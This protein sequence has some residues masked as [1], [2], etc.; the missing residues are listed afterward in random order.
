MLVKLKLYQILNRIKLVHKKSTYSDDY[1][2]GFKHAIDLFAV[3]MDIEFG[4]WCE[5]QENLHDQ[6]RV[7]QKQLKER[8][9]E[10][11]G[12]S[13]EIN[14]LKAQPKYILNLPNNQLR[15]LI[16]QISKTTGFTF[17]RVKNLLVGGVKIDRTRVIKK[18][19]F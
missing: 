17:G 19:S 8:T 5:D 4:E 16:D 9:R 1:N 14:R 3:A 2:K 11:S 10:L 7:L 18:A 12:Q 13:H 15:I 6:I